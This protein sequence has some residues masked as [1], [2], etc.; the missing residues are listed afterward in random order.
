[1]STIRTLTYSLVTAAGSG[2][3]PQHG[4]VTITT[5]GAYIY[6]PDADFNGTDLFTFKANDGSAD[7]NIATINLSVTPVND[8]PWQIT[9]MSAPRTASF[10]AIRWRPI[11]IYLHLQHRRWPG[12]WDGHAL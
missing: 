1:M 7:S 10:P 6:T 3:D 2:V 12:P 8:A 9:T 11:Q 5:S 4:S